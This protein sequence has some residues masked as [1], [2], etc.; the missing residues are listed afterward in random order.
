MASNKLRLDDHN[1]IIE[2]L[3]SQVAGLPAVED[4]TAELEEQNRVIT[5]LEAKVDELGAV[6]V[7]PQVAENT[8][9]IAQILAELEGKAVP[10]VPSAPNNI[11]FGEKTLSSATTSVTVE[12]S[13]NTIPSYAMFIYKSNLETASK[14]AS[15]YMNSNGYV[16]YYN[17]ITNANHI[18]SVPNNLTSQNVTFN[19]Y[20]S[21]EVN[22]FIAGNYIWFVT[23]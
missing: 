17:P 15:C 10:S 3:I 8:D 9:L 13:L 12:H 1:D 7:T 22:G 20:T 2:Q 6:D 11:C 5:K 18:A 16:A 21:S 23:V 14:T 19:A 4:L